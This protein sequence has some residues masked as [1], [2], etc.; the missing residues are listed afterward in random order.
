MSCS[1][2]LLAGGNSTRFGGDTPK[3][4]LELGGLPIALHSFQLL[5]NSPLINEIVVICPEAYRS[6]FP[7]RT[8]FA[9]PGTRRQDSV[10]SGLKKLTGDY[11][12]IH[13]AA[14]PFITEEMIQKTLEAAQKCGAAATAIPAKDTIRE[15]DEN[16][17]V[18]RT[19]DRSCLFHMQ[20]PQCIRKDLLEKGILSGI[21]V[22]DDVA[23]SDE[24]QLV[25]GSPKNIKITTPEDFTL[26]ELFLCPTTN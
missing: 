11:I 12:L 3:Q 14:R 15:C 16:G 17:K 8:L 9:N 23:F 6:L 19:P 18:I 21:E 13:D 7:T 1:A 20:T 4:F 25:P 24:I 5:Q 10:A 2:I 26:A 22:T